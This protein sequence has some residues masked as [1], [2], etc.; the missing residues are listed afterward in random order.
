MCSN[1]RASGAARPRSDPRLRATPLARTPRK[2]RARDESCNST[3]G[4]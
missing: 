1:G 4:P 3:R 2:V